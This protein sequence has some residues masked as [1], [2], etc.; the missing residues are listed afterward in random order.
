MAIVV[1]GDPCPATFDQI[2]VLSN[3]VYSAFKGGEV[4]VRFK[5][6]RF[7]VPPEQSID[8]HPN[9]VTK[10][11]D[12]L[13]DACQPLPFI[14]ELDFST[15]PGKEVTQKDGNPAASGGEK[16]YRYFASK[17][18]VLLRKKSGTRLVCLSFLG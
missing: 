4:S 8:E 17:D 6:A 11:C 16:K 5:A 3:P 12:C 10:A 9:P 18:A 14:A 7:C 15:S 2:F 13:R 1:V